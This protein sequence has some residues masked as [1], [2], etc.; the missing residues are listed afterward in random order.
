MTGIENF[1]E[2]VNAL[3]DE[4]WKLKELSREYDNEKELEE[5]E[6]LLKKGIG[7]KLRTE[8]E[9]KAKEMR[10]ERERIRDASLRIKEVINDLLEI[11][12]YFGPNLDTR[13]GKLYPYD[14]EHE[15]LSEKYISAITDIL[16]GE[17][18]TVIKFENATLSKDGI[19]VEADDEISSLRILNYVMTII[20]ES[21]KKKLGKENEIDKEWEKLKERDYAYI[22]FRTIMT[23]EER[24]KS[25]D[26]EE[27]KN[28][29][30][31]KD[32]DYRALFRE[33]YDKG[34]EESLRY[35]SGEEMKLLRYDKDGYYSVTDFGE[36]VWK[37]CSKEEDEMKRI[38]EKRKKKK[39]WITKGLRRG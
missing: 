24:K 18:S 4:Y 39:L 23:S 19:E 12:S 17:P 38:I 32:E 9:K 11:S 15:P 26:K 16:F 33:D 25:M 37:L 29:A 5:I 3:A 1:N 2:R 27:I 10:Q 28:I 30:R 13:K 8:L 34:I 6:E 36:W 31:I 14:E 20:Q 7:G 35:L 21:A 22:A